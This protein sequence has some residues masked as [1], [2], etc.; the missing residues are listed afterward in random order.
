MYQKSGMPKLV[1]KII[2]TYNTTESTVNYYSYLYCRKPAGLRKWKG[3]IHFITFGSPTF[4][5]HL[6]RI[7]KEAKTSGFFDTITIFTEEDLPVA[8]KTQYSINETTRGFGYWRWKSYITRKKLEEIAKDDILVYLDAGCAINRQ[9]KKRYFEYLNL[10]L[11]SDYSNVSFDTIYPE[12]QYTKEDLFRYFELD[13][14]DPVKNSG[15]LSCCPFLIKKDDNSIRIVDQW[16]SIC[17]DHKELID[18]SP[19][20]H[21]SDPNFIEHRHDQSVFSLLRKTRGTVII[22]NEIKFKEW[23]KNLNFPFHIHRFK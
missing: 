4:K 17:H 19:S 11:N 18:D 8:Y 10:L 23:K 9:G 13:E 7:Y 16:F 1:R 15:Q 22:Q 3:Q 20:S 21:S 5:D 6:E 2:Q 14:N 12:K